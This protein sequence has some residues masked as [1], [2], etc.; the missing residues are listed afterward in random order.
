MNKALARSGNRR[1]WMIGLAALVSVSVGSWWLGARSQSPEQAASRAAAPVASWITVPVEERVLASTVVVRGDVS[2]LVSLSMVVPSSVE[3]A[4][5]VTRLPPAVGTE[6]VEGAVVIEVSGRPVFVVQ[7]DVPTYRSLRPGMWGPDVWQLQSALFRLGF[8]GEVSG[9]FD[10][11]TE[12]N[13]KALYKAA[14]YEPV[15]GNTVAFGELVFLPTFP[16]RV[17]SGVSRLG[18]IVA[19]SAT[20]VSD[21]SG[22]VVL[23]A[24]E[25]LVTTAVRAGDE[26]LVRVGMGVEVLNE[27][28]GTIYTGHLATIATTATMDASGQMGR[29][30]TI[31][32]DEP[33]PASLTNV[34]VR[35]TITAAASDGEVLVVPL[36]AVSSAADTSTRVSVLAAGATTPVDVA[37]TAGISAD[38]FVAVEPVVKGTL[39]VGDLVVVGR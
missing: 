13:V 27:T 8:G 32:T 1:V 4:G 34:N 26:G 7:G 28:S 38:G 39:H 9:V 24:G 21:V 36:A 12:A 6:V 11:A 23:S 20:G 25:L 29:V 15:D 10:R 33:L 19:G 37:V 30:A 5:V 2:P 35:V 14:G 16:A 31:A 17:Q 18:P 22:L 3:G